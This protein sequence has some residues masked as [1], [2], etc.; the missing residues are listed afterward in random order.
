MVIRGKDLTG[1]STVIIDIFGLFSNHIK[2]L[3][4]TRQRIKKKPELSLIKYFET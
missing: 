1:E 3:F 2:K 4:L